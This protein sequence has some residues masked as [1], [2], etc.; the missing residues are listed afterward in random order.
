M[1]CQMLITKETENKGKRNQRKDASQLKTVIQQ[2][3]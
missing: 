2:H 1:V 3:I